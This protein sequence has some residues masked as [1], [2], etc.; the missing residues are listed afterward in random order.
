MDYHSGLYEVV[1][2]SKHTTASFNITVFEDLIK[3]INETFILTIVSNTLP[4]G[5]S[6]H[7]NQHTTTVVI[8]DTTGEKCSYLQRSYKASI[9]SAH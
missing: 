7:R 5:V 4:N 1:F 3:E 9:S 2:A 6:H 8:I